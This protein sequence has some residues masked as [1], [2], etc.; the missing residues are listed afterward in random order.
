[1]YLLECSALY[2][3]VSNSTIWTFSTL[4]NFEIAHDSR[5]VKYTDMVSPRPT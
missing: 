3:T 2:S 4:I 1:M 5:I